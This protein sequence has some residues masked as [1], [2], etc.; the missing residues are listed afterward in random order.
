MLKRSQIEQMPAGEIVAEMLELEAQMAD[1]DVQADAQWYDRVSEEHAALRNRLDEIEM[2]HEVIR[3]FPY[4][5]RSA[6]IDGFS[7][8]GVTYVPFCGNRISPEV[9][10][11]RRSL[12]TWSEAA[13]TAGYTV[14]FRRANGQAVS[15]LGRL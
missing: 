11:R 10:E 14:T 8:N 5:M 15:A 2:P 1:P 13:C 4:E 9:A 12:G 7:L 6:D 3:T